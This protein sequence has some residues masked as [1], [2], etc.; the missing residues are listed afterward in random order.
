MNAQKTVLLTGTFPPPMGGVA[1]INKLIV[2]QLANSAYRIVPLNSVRFKCIRKIPGRRLAPLFLK[3]AEF[4]SFIYLIIRHRCQIVHIALSSYSSFYKSAIFI[5]IAGLLR[6]KI[7]IHLHGGSFEQ[8]YDDS[9]NFIKK[10]IC[11]AFEKSDTVVTLSEKWRRFVSE[12]LAI[13]PG[14]IA[15]LNNSYGHEFDGF[16]VPDEEL[17]HRQNG[18]ICKLLF[19]GSISR[20]KGVIDLLESCARLSA[21][22][23]NYQLLLAGGEKEPGILK[24]ID[25]LI[26]RHHLAENVKLLGEVDAEQKLQVFAESDIFILPSHAENFPVAI[27]EAMRAG[28][29]V[30]ASKVGAV[31]EIIDEPDNGLLFEAGD[32]TSLTEKIE[33][34]LKDATL[35]Q[36]MAIKNMNKALIDFNPNK[37]GSNLIKIY[38]RLI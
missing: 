20:K 25:D 28:L 14:K 5:L 38:D 36:S 23:E 22:S 17:L 11:A 3:P 35:R 30:I 12:K 27:I 37:H 16:K 33:R 7:V 29:P 31:A 6:R 10:C 1:A 34:L 13:T 21:H 8:F 26:A 18:N 19:L 15:I 4:I 9:P 24:R 2:R 32:I